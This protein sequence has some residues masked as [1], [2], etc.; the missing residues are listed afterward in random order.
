M[1]QFRL[2]KYL[3]RGF[4]VFA[5]L[6]FV[7]IFIYAFK[8][9]MEMESVGEQAPFTNTLRANNDTLP[10]QRSITLDEP[11]RTPRE[12]SLWVSQSVS[13][14]LTFDARN[15]DAQL[16]KAQPYF[17]ATGYKEYQSYLQQADIKNTL[18]HSDLKANVIVEEPPLLL[19]SGAVSGVFRWLYEVQITMSYTPRELR[20]LH[21]SSAGEMTRQLTVRLQLGRHDDA[22]MGE[23]V[24][25]ETWSVSAR[26][27]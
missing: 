22:A 21:P 20:Q 7:G 15:F 13:E 17:S 19:N 24:R 2:Q 25:I 6:L 11:H 12:L 4:Y 5:F 1:N 27:K 16:K 10:P 9:E 23:G 14:V 18:H 8:T 3:F 26:R